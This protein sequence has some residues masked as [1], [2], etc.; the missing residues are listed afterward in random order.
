MPKETIAFVIHAL[1][2]GGAE[3]VVSTL[4]NNL[5]HKYKV[6]IITY[7]K[8]IPFYYLSPDI[9][10]VY[11]EE[12]I[13][14]SQNV[15]QA[16]MVNYKLFI[17]IKR[18]LK[19]EKVKITI[20]FMTSAN[21]LAILASRLNKIPVIISERSN[22]YLTKLPFI[23]RYLRKFVY[24]HA[25]SLIVQTVENKNYFANFID[26]EKI[27]IVANPIAQE[28]TSAKDSQIIKKNVVLNVGRFISGKAQDQLIKAF[29]AIDHKDWELHLI[30]KGP[31][32]KKYA[33]LISKLGLDS[34]IKLI[35]PTTDIAVHYN[36]AKVFAFTSLSEGFPN[37][38]I[39]AMHFGISCISTDCPTGPS[40]V[41][42]HRKNGFLIPMNDQQA[43]QKHLSLLMQSSDLRKR[44]GRLA[45][46]SVERFE[47][48]AISKKW[49]N[50][51]E[52]AKGQISREIRT[53]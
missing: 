38:L 49:E 30:G 35:P 17:K 13:P 43:L 20:G 23:W 45:E 14:L 37:A 53:G 44:L 19:Q 2:S 46:A 11:C 29:A 51:I 7:K 16:L 8:S 9:T 28:L 39:E 24:R 32:E 42:K 5:S 41:I 12:H 27:E 26:Y 50:V 4:A 3:R 36:T 6:L 18:F 1:G 40:E 31:Q 48:K 52:R 34:C 21:V 10:I 15:F 22:P 47:V 33:G 25:D